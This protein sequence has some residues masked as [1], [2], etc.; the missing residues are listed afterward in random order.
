MKKNY[1]DYSF[2]KKTLLYLPC[3]YFSYTDRV[4]DYNC[5]CEEGWGGK[6][7]SVELTGCRETICLNNG[8]CTPWLVGETDHRADC[9]CEPGYTGQRCQNET[10]FSMKGNSYIKVPS[11]NGGDNGQGEGYE[12]TMRFRTTLGDGLVAIGQLEG[13]SYFRLRLQNG[14]LNL[15]S[16]LISKED[17]LKL[18]ENLNNTNWQKVLFIMFTK[19]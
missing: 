19:G 1:T 10:T 12:L 8:T 17:G 11:I 2:F 14:R 7:C 3:I 9:A 18:G 5:S 16:N 15:H 4:N 6:N 13:D